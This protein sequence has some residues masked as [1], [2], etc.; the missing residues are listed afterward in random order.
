MPS[1]DPFQNFRFRVEINNVQH[2]GFMRAK[3]IARETKID[4]YREGG[5]NEFEHKLASMTTYGNIVLERGLVDDY[6]WSW[7]EAV[8]EGRIERRAMTILLVDPAGA[9]QWRWLVEGAF[10]V[11]WSG[12]DLDGLSA[13]TLIESVELAHHGFRRG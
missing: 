13:Q 12:S 1:R 10:P 6:L 9:T 3:G 7:N 11:K 8:V 5:L 2:G 4:A